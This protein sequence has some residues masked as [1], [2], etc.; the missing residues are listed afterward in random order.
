MGK[1]LVI[2]PSEYN[3]PLISMGANNSG[4]AAEASKFL[5]N[6]PSLTISPLPVSRF[7]RVI[8]S[9]FFSAEN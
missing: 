1:L 4:K 6:G 2:P 8:K 9:G 7:V 3:T 5:I